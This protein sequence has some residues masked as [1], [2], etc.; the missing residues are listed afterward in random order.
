MQYEKIQLEIDGDVAVLRLNDPTA[1]NAVTLQM[2]QEI[3]AALDEIT[4]SARA[5]LV[6]SVGRA[7][8]AGANL[9]G[10]LGDVAEDG[11]PDAG[12][13]LESDINPMMSRFRALP[14]PWVTAVRGPAAGVGCSL[15]LAADLI[16]ASE[17]AYFLQAFARIGLVPDGGSSWLLNRA[18]GR[19][20]AMEMMLLGERLPAAKALEW[21]LINRLVAE[22]ELENAGLTL[23]R[24]LAQGPTRSLGMVREVAWAAVDQNWEQALATERRMQR[25]AGRTADHQE[26][27]AAFLEKRPAQF[28]GA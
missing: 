9:S 27:V 7:F 3:D 12:A 16:V 11:L 2:I 13:V 14:F 18:V 28:T 26:G 25:E 23:A 15:A 4:G 24:S 21:G 22:T 8:C 20:R 5:L 17:S 1:L 10:G 6:T 19:V